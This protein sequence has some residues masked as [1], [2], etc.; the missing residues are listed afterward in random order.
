S[1]CT[2]TY[3]NAPFPAV[4][5]LIQIQK[6]RHPKKS[7]AYFKIYYCNLLITASATPSA[8]AGF[9]PVIKLPLETTFSSPASPF[10]KPAP[11]SSCFVCSINCIS[12]DKFT[13]SSSA[14]VN[15]VSLTPSTKY[16]P[17]L[18]FASAKAAGP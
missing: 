4:P 6:K 2:C 12:S 18:V 8:D 11:F 7:T 14:F 1:C 16:L 13:A 15:A 9:C 5:P 3:H 10:T 17:S